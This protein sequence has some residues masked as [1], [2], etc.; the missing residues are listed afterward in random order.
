MSTNF[1]KDLFERGYFNEH[2]ILLR[3]ENGL[4]LKDEDGLFIKQNFDE[5][6]KDFELHEVFSVKEYVK[7]TAIRFYVHYTYNNKEY[8][9]RYLT[10]HISSIVYDYVKT[11]KE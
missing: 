7:D 1:I 11:I 10:N 6:L 9:R 8:I 3:D 5:F 4:Y 2:D